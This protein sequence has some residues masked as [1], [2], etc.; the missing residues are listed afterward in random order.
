MQSARTLPKRNDIVDVMEDHEV[1]RL[2]LEMLP[3]TLTEKRA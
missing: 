3:P 2:N 1:W